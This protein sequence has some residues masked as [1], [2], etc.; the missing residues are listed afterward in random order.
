[1]RPLFCCLYHVALWGAVVKSESNL[2]PRNSISSMGVDEPNSLQ[3]QR[4]P[5]A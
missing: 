2:T 3:E 4:K 5:R 1:M